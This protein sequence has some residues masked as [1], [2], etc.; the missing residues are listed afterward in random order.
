M[1]SK[2]RQTMI[3]VLEQYLPNS[4]P[5]QYGANTSC[6]V[7]LCRVF[8]ILCRLREC[9]CL[10]PSGT[11]EAQPSWSSSSPRSRVRSNNNLQHNLPHPGANL[12]T[13]SGYTSTTNLSRN[14]GYRSSSLTMG[15]LPLAYWIQEH[16]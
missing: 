4:T 14:S 1:Y 13:P 16:V 9:V 8:Y 6:L 3:G 10:R 5:I 12:A 15:R 2:E 11:T 7:K